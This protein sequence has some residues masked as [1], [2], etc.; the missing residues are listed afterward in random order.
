MVFPSTSTTN[1]PRYV[2]YHRHRRTPTAEGKKRN[3]YFMEGTT[4]DK[5]RR[6]ARGGARPPPHFFSGNDYLGD[7]DDFDQAT[8]EDKLITFLKLDPAEYNLNGSNVVP[9]ST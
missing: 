2:T 4:R 3:G 6:D 7:Y 1:G 5:E 9:H 8:E